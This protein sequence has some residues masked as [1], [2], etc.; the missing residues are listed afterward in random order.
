VLAGIVLALSTMAILYRDRVQ[1]FI[2][3]LL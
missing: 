2:A 3:R 1:G